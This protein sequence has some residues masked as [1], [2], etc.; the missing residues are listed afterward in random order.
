[1]T[2]DY[3]RNMI[4][5]AEGAKSSQ[6]QQTFASLAAKLFRHYL[7]LCIVHI[8]LLSGPKGHGQGGASIPR[9]FFFWGGGASLR[10]FCPRSQKKTLVTSLMS[11]I[12]SNDVQILRILAADKSATDDRPPRPMLWIA[13]P[14]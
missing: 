14:R 13:T 11:L 4:K 1:M 7:L 8:I 5:V 3:Q 6:S 9:I 12:V 2:N 10:Y